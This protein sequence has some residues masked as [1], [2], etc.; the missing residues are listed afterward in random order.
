MRD[1]AFFCTTSKTKFIFTPIT[2]YTMLTTTTTA[3]VIILVLCLIG[4]ACCATVEPFALSTPSYP[5]NTCIAYEANP[6]GNYCNQYTITKPLHV[7]PSTTVKTNG[8][9]IGNQTLQAY[10]NQNAVIPPVP[11]ISK[12]MQ[13]HQAL[14]QKSAKTLAT[15]NA[16]NVSAVMKGLEENRRQVQLVKNEFL[17]DVVQGLKDWQ[18]VKSLGDYTISPWSINNQQGGENVKN[19]RVIAYNAKGTSAVSTAN[20]IIYKKTFVPCESMAQNMGRAQQEPRTYTLSFFGD[21]YVTGVWI[22][23]QFIGPSSSE[24]WWEQTRYTITVAPPSSKEKGMPTCM[25]TPNQTATGKTCTVYTTTPLTI[26]IIVKNYG[27]SPSGVNYGNTP[28]PHGLIAT[29]QDINN[30]LDVMHT[31]D[32]WEYCIVDSPA[33]LMRIFAEAVFTPPTEAS[34][35]APLCTLSAE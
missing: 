18:P 5:Q 26:Y 25:T 22:N 23:D 17:E 30:T 3:L 6:D 34:T 24:N 13:A 29:L 20:A 10:M 31:D 27:K 9:N 19:A 12:S 4:V 7:N 1:D 21:N 15:S 28:N 2:F 16:A 14:L 32:T 33:A 11:A 35:S 8:L